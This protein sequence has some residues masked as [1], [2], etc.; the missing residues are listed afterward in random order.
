MTTTI[1]DVYAAYGDT[2]G[3]AQPLRSRDALRSALHSRGWTHYEGITNADLDAL[4]DADMAA[5]AHGEEVS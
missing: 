3:A 5:L 2:F 4:Y 1:N